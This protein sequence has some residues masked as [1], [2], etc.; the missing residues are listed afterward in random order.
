MTKHA[1][2]FWQTREV[3]F[4]TADWEALRN[5]GTI[6][7]Q[8]FGAEVIAIVW[9]DDDEQTKSN[10][11]LIAA[12]PD[13]IAALEA[14]IKAFEHWSA[15]GG[16]NGRPEFRKSALAAWKEATQ[17]SRAAIAKARGEG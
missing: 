1:A 17:Q 16:S 10:A 12:A 6:V 5:S 7:T 14:Q 2:G 11:D 4:E 9:G 15:C 13:M 3:V 8:Q